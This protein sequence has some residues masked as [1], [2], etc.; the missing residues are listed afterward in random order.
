MSIVW[1]S[2][3]WHLGHRGITDRLRKEFD[4]L[5]HMEE[6]IIENHASVVNKRD[7][8]IIVGD[9]SFT[10]EGLAQLH[11]IPGRKILV[12]GNHDTLPLSEYVEVFDDIHGAMRYKGAFV[13]HIPIHP[14]EL[15]RGYNIHG[16]CH[17]GGP[18]ELQIG[19]DWRSYYNVILEYNDYKPV[20]VDHIWRTVGKIK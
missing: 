6:I 2:S 18:R 14:C 16:H 4:N 5:Q 19:E 7:T 11:R 10:S 8:L 9:V 3:D 20:P 13:T 12:R 15:Y 17:K 1:F